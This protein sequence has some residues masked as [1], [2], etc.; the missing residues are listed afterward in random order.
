MSSYDDTLTQ[1][2]QMWRNSDMWAQQSMSPFTPMDPTGGANN[3]QS[4]MYQS[5]YNLESAAA[6]TNFMGFYQPYA[7]QALAVAERQSIVSGAA[8]GL[9]SGAL[10]AMGVNPLL[11]SIAGMGVSSLSPEIMQAFGMAE[12]NPYIDVDTLTASM[13]AESLHQTAWNVLGPGQTG[14]FRGTSV[15]EAKRGATYLMDQMRSM[16]MQG[17]ELINMLPAL[18]DSGLL[19]SST[20]F[21]SMINKATEVISK[22]SDFIKTTGATITEAIQY[23]TLGGALGADVGQTFNMLQNA[24]NVSMGTGT[25]ITNL[26]QNA[27]ALTQPFAMAAGNRAGII[28]GYLELAS[29][30]GVA[31]DRYSAYDTEFAAAGG[32]AG[33]G[34]IVAQMGLERMT[35]QRA[36]RFFAA[37]PEAMSSYMAEG[38]IPESLGDTWEGL[39]A[40]QRYE[41]YYN[42][43]EFIADN[44]ENLAR[45]RRSYFDRVWDEADLNS[46]EA[47]AGWLMQ[48]RGM[49][50]SEAISYVLAD[51][52]DPGL[53]WQS[54][55]NTFAGSV[56]GRFNRQQENVRVLLNQAGAITIARRE[57][58]NDITDEEDDRLQAGGTVHDDWMNELN[59]STSSAF[60]EVGTVDWEAVASR[61]FESREEVQLLATAVAN[62]AAANN[63][64][65]SITPKMNDNGTWSFTTNDP[66]QPTLRGTMFENMS[67][68]T[69]I[70]SE[71]VLAALNAITA[72]S[73]TSFT[74]LQTATSR[75]AIEESMAYLRGNDALTS[76]L[77][78]VLSPHSGVIGSRINE[79]QIASTL[80]TEEIALNDP[81]IQRYASDLGVDIISERIT[82]GEITSY[83]GLLDAVS[84]DVFGTSYGNLRGERADAARALIAFYYGD[85]DI[86]RPSNDPS[87]MFSAINK[88]QSTINEYSSETPEMVAMSRIYAEYSVAE[89]QQLV[90]DL[91]SGFSTGESAAR[92]AGLIGGVGIDEARAGAFLSDNATMIFSA[93]DYLAE[94][95]GVSAANR[96]AFFEAIINNNL[97]EAASYATNTGSQMYDMITSADSA[98]DLIND[99]LLRAS[100]TAVSAQKEEGRTTP[101]T[102]FEQMEAV[103]EEVSRARKTTHADA[104]K[105]I[106]F[107]QPVVD[108]ISTMADGISTMANLMALQQSKFQLITINGGVPGDGDNFVQRM[109]QFIAGGFG[110]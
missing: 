55:A 9:T 8:F 34:A 23:A 59:I 10:S 93:T 33:A 26:I 20:D 37:G 2:E 72:D 24:S 94:G 96:G 77:Y 11:S 66:L 16:G 62:V 63:S 41:A 58:G 64:T 15:S 56:E 75:Y 107:L 90:Q 81:R 108:G 39:N 78:N 80:P 17:T 54:M 98:T 104:T 29:I 95:V 48:N 52:N 13:M 21:E 67:Y 44:Y 85:R 86:G 68:Q 87:S 71:A 3:Q 22:I 36:A 4:S 43:D 31:D 5:R 65:F 99:A 53:R 88:A 91:E 12:Q 109:A 70:S 27:S 57:R 40:T 32:A 83:Q 25:P 79:Y 69:P 35:R 46:N 19:E 97:A 82:A 45:A 38:R 47:R 101:T 6:R 61:Q 7:E 100:E 84:G 18:Q 110:A 50:G 14:G 89:R 42:A 105:L 28:E 106:N 49:S 76:E 1:A 51:P 103:A 73:V 102:M 92:W 30:A 60:T 74:G